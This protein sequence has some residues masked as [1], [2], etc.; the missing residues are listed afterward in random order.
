MLTDNEIRGIAEDSLQF[1][2]FAQTLEEIITT[3]ETPIT[4]GVY[5][6][7]GSGKTSLM[8]M[9]QDILKDKIK[10]VWFDAW[11]FDKTYDLRVALIHAILMR[12]NKDASISSGLKAKVEKLLKRV[13]WLG[14]GKAA[15][16]SF[17][18]QLAIWQEKEPLLKNQEEIPGKT[19]ELIGDFEAEFKE[20]TNEYVG[21]EGRLVVFIDDLDR[22][23]SEKTID[24]LEAIK[25]FLNV[26]HSVFV[27]GADRKRIEEG[28]IDKYG[29]KSE[30]W[31][32]NYLE[33]IVQIPFTLPPLRKDVIAEEF[34]KQLDIS[35]EI[36]KYTS[37]LAEVGDNPRRIKRLLNSFEVKRIL[38][39][40]RE[41]EIEENIMAKLA[42]IEFRWH[43]YYTDLIGIYSE[44]GTN[45]AKILKETSESEE[46]EKEKKLK[47]WGNLRKYLEDKRLMDFLDQEPPLWD[48]DIDHYVYLA[49]STTE[50]KESAVNYFNIAYSFDE[51]GEYEKAIENYDIAIDLKPNYEDA[52]YN[53]GVNLGK[54]ERHNEAIACYD[55]ALDLNPNDEKA[56]HNKGVMLERLER[57]EEAI[58]CYDKAIE[59]KPNYEE[60]WYGKGVNLG[61]LERHE[62]AIACY[63][64]AVELNPNYEKAWYGKGVR[65]GGLERHEEAIACYD[66]A[67]DLNPNDGDAWFN[68]GWTLEKLGRKDEAEPCF[69]KAKELGYEES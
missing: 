23:I 2:V 63:D 14:L 49:R 33:K 28:I 61:G 66:K 68:K 20:L 50:L 45:L 59:L 44:T 18:P 1:K 47:E 25:L 8:R 62:E 46:A 56:W 9:T 3:S 58:A 31:A 19:L 4:I 34:F 26:Q 15:L 40:K 32:G 55:K 22:C 36:R 11:K 51:K 17:I 64:K 24:I 41:L 6:A 5:G 67:L 48:V 16:S 39:E 27:I 29:K 37:I 53:K 12:M 13:N 60:A 69:Q 21:D 52:W 43:D 42:V 7:W 10:T 57:H 35:D 54:L 38:A 65:L 30:S